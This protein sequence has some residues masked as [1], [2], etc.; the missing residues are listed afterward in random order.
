MEETWYKLDNAAKIYPA[1]RETNWAP[2]F[3][4][5]AVLKEKVHPEILQ[6]ALN[7]TYRRFPTFSV[8]FTKGLFWY[9]F[10]PNEC[11]PEVRM[12][13]DYA[14]A[15]FSEE[16]DKGYLFRV[17]YYNRRI[18]LE[19][20]HSI[21]D[22][23]GAT[24]FLKTLIFNYITSL[25]GEE[26]IKEALDLDRY[27]IFHY[28]DLPSAEE[29]E[30]SFFHVAASEDKLNL[31]ESIAFKIKGTPIKRNTLKVLHVIV[32]VNSLKAAANKFNAT[33]TE[34]LTA[35][36]IHSVLNARLYHPGEKKPIK[37]S[38]PIN[39]RKRFASKTVR[40]FSS[41]VNVEYKP[42][43]EADNAD[44][45]EICREVSRQ[46]REG[47]EISAL[48]SK[49]SGNVNAEKNILMRLAPL[50]LK[51]L[52]LK[53]NFSL[54]GE[55]ITTSTLSNIGNLTLPVEMIKY[56]DRFDFVLGAPRE[57]VFNCAVISF[58]D[59]MSISFTSTILEN[60]VTKSFTDSLVSYGIS[61]SVEANY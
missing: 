23:F 18:S 42:E 48:R 11:E 37:I 4:I 43:V 54:Y 13:S 16:K 45:E 55:R 57:N 44:L 33:V 30:D 47:T 41:Y 39:L 56:I 27:N 58:N 31:K 9:Y 21:T 38:V 7:I 32:S 29:T 34:F 20:F 51:N 22:G 28:K 26:P 53:A 6:K 8:H 19:V 36:F 12:E 61:V 10:E 2:V 25:N 49:F 59:V 24:V 35:L 52:V 5:D 15:P 17:L 40:N 3:R 14:A 1:I 60:T 46:I 50:F